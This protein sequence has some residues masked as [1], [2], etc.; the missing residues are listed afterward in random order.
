MM[1]HEKLY[2]PYKIY[3]LDITVL[4]LYVSLLDAERLRR[5]RS[6][7]EVSPYYP[8]T[9]K[10][11][12]TFAKWKKLNNHSWKS[13]L[14]PLI[15]FICLLLF[16]FKAII[17]LSFPQ[18]RDPKTMEYLDPTL[19]FFQRI[20]LTDIL[21]KF[22]GSE[23]LHRLSFIL[24]I[25]QIMTIVFAIRQQFED[26]R[27]NYDRYR[28]INILQ[29]D[30]ESSSSYAG[31]LKDWF[32]FL[33]FGLTHKCDL[34]SPEAR[35]YFEASKRLSASVKDSD[36]LER[37]IFF[38]QI[39]FSHCFKETNIRIAN[40]KEARRSPNSLF[41]PRKAFNPTPPWRLDPTQLTVALILSFCGGMILIIFTSIAILSI[42]ISLLEPTECYDRPIDFWID[43]FGNLFKF[44]NFI[45]VLESI[46]ICICTS[47]NVL[48]V[49]IFAYANVSLYSRIGRVRNLFEVERGI[50]R[51]YQ[52]LLARS[53]D[54]EIAESGC[55]LNQDVYEKQIESAKSKFLQRADDRSIENMNGNLR[56]LL[57]LIEVLKF[58]LND[59]RS[60]FTVYMNMY[61]CFGTI[62]FA[63]AP[64][65]FT[66]SQASKEWFLM[67][68]MYVATLIPISAVLIF[69]A[70]IDSSVST[71][72]ISDGINE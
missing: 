17:Y 7:D 49:S 54:I 64:N 65:V 8:G 69:A 2:N 51:E 9:N 53:I 18:D 28:K 63:L 40:E 32:N 29:V 6:S 15:T 19:K 48:H 27:C 21:Y 35:E 44:R 39:D 26:A 67:L 47:N 14:I 23:N 1:T 30:V 12:S 68:S 60:F 71:S 33:V 72:D 42:V 34:R 56:F 37:L 41:G 70:T 66:T 4:N 52:K 36:R 3:F 50:H 11:R 20:Y 59:M 13:F 46:M 24:F 22:K 43:T 31:T 45:L 16:T 62:G 57:N 10:V 58:E 38:N 5:N 25:N 55:S 61:I